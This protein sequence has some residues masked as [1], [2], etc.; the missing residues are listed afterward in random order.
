MKSETQLE[1]IWSRARAD[2]V[3]EIDPGEEDVFLWEHS[4]RVARSAIQ[5]TEIP[6]VRR[7]KVNSVAV[8]AAALYHDAGWIETARTSDRGRFEVLIKPSSATQ[9]ERG[10]TLMEQNLRDIVSRPS[11]LQAKEA[12]LTLNDRDIESIEGQIL[13]EAEN[14]EEFGLLALWSM[15]RRG[16]QEGKGVQAVVDTWQR[17]KEYQFWTARLRDSFRFDEVR[18]LASR[19]LDT[20]EQFMIGLRRQHKGDDLAKLGISSQPASSIS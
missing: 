20:F 3:L 4:A 12:I 8:T 2:L 10:A 17:R 5:I 11:L 6:S 7:E 9:R 16:A 13:S 15:I 14:L 18:E 1:A 19:R